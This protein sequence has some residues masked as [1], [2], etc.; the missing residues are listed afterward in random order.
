MTL[1]AAA[2]CFSMVRMLAADVARLR[3]HS[4]T[5]EDGR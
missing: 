2:L 5:A 3:A 1:G 4:D